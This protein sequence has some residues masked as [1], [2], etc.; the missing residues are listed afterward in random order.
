V[1]LFQIVGT[2][3]C[4]TIVSCSEDGT[5][6][7]WHLHDGSACD[8]EGGVPS[9]EQVLIG[10]TN[11]SALRELSDGLSERLRHQQSE[12]QIALQYQE[13]TFAES[14]AQMS[15]CKEKEV[16]EIRREIKQMESRHLNEL[17]EK[18]RK[19]EETLSEHEV[20]VAG[21]EDEYQE[22]LIFEYGRVE[23]L[24]KNLAEQKQLF[25][26]LRIFI[27]MINYTRKL[28]S[29]PKTKIQIKFFFQNY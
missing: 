18:M 8:S 7:I 29:I 14:E 16:A 17:E 5:I 23:Q 22:K 28:P 4:K 1:P 13:A 11:L 26:Q 12:K 2:Y 24:E 10:R 9:V 27:S 15:Q 21:L 3:D 20:V 6:C 19:L 25:E